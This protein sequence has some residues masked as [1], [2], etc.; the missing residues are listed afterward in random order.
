MEWKSFCQDLVVAEL[1]P[2]DYAQYR[3][4]VADALIYFL[5]NLP[6]W[7]TDRILADQA[8]LPVTASI[9]ERMVAIA[10]HSPVLH[11]LGQLLGRDRR[12]PMHFRS[13]L[14]GLESMRPQIPGEQVREALHREVQTLDQAEIDVAEEPIAEAS[15]AVVIP[16]RWRGGPGGT[17][18]RGVFKLLKPDIE[19]I[20]HE[21]LAL[22]ARVGMLLDER[23]EHYG[24]PR[25]DYEDF[26]T[27]MRELLSNEVDLKLE[28]KNMKAARSAFSSQSK[29]VVP[30][31][32]PMCTRR[33]TAM[34][35]IDGRSVTE[36]SGVRSTQRSRIAQTIVEAILAHPIWSQD[37]SA[38]FH[39]DPHAGNLFLTRDGRIALLDWSLVGKLS[40]SDRIHISRILSGA[41]TLNQPQ[42]VESLRKLADQPLDRDV[43]SRIVDSGLRSIRHGQLPGTTWVAD[44]LGDAV[45]EGRAKFGPG[46][47]MFRKVLYTV[48]GVVADVMED[49]SIDVQL[50][51]S[52][53]CRFIREWPERIVTS[54]FSRSHRTHLSNADLLNVLGAGPLTA[55]RYWRGEIRK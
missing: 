51:R 25:I 55:A 37:D 10:R 52:F 5:E 47:L 41:V 12:L 18:Q 28:Q 6:S 39:A 9:E 30:E 2:D 29:I 38:P 45:T 19:E 13:L 4:P 46:L 1:V 14:Q 8:A 54:P 3:S 7:R 20:L 44:L 22:L 49:W 36:I 24:I 42:I 23:C 50:V 15:V 34:E 31:L 16:F 27:Q 43:I 17:S 33:V 26:F 40:K 11:K 35:R 53:L 48:E 21:D 32:F